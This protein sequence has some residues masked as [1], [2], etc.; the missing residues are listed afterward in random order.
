MSRPPRRAEGDL[1]WTENDRQGRCSISL[2]YGVVS[3]GEW[4]GRKSRRGEDG[5]NEGGQLEVIPDKDKGLGE[6]KR[7]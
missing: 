3:K 4:R 1:T 7:S 5:T 2:R 6:A